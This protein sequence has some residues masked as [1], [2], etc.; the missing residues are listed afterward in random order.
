MSIATTILE[1]LGGHKF[2]A[3]TGSKNFMDDGDTLRMTLAKNQSKANRLYI[4]L[5]GLDA[6]DLHFFNYTPA[7][8]NPKTLAWKDE[9][10]VEIETVTDVYAVD[11]QRVFT[12]VTGMDTHL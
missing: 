5:N 7:K 2:T 11:L 10:I 4:T 1:Q 12:R 9:K 8:F 3:M 6:Y